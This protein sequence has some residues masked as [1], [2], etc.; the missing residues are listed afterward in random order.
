[1]NDK[2]KTSALTIQKFLVDLFT[3]RSWG[4]GGETP[5]LLPQRGDFKGADPLNLLKIFDPTFYKKLVGVSGVKPLTCFFIRGFGGEAP[6][7]FPHKGVSGVKPL[8]TYPKITINICTL[9]FLEELLL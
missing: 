1:M 7:L 2:L 5:E 6:D 8:T 9:T 3:K 4:F